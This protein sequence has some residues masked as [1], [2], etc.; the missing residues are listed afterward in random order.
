[1]DRR[2]AL[3]RMAQAAG[4][5]LCV[6][7]ERDVVLINARS[8]EQ[9]ALLS[10]HAT[11]ISALLAIGKE[12]WTAAADETLRVWNVD[13]RQ[14]LAALDA[15]TGPVCSLLLAGNYVWCSGRDGL[16]RLFD[17]KAFF[18]VKELERKHHAPISALLYVGDNRVWSG[19]LDRTFGIWIFPSTRI[20]LPAAGAPQPQA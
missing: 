8:L 20:P 14:C 12:L 4:H 5:V 9:L 11:R 10:G 7:A 6:V 15:T 16:I 13:T 17:S 19:S 1:M 3:G 2:V 18:L